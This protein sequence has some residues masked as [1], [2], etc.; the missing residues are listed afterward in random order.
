ML[1]GIVT[2][3]FVAV[4]WILFRAVSYDSAMASLLS[5]LRQFDPRTI[6]GFYMARP[7]FSWM[8]L[9]AFALVFFP[10]SLRE[11]VEQRLRRLP[12]AAMV[13]ML[14]CLLQIILQVKD[15]QIQPFIYFQF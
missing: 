12:P 14:T 13:L 11:P 10:A 8:M 4:L 15:Q 3:H 6:P 5:M 7:E 9:L 1:S 2:F